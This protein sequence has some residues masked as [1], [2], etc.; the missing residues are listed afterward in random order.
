VW[1]SACNFCDVIVTLNRYL[2]HF[3]IKLCDGLSFFFF[4]IYITKKYN[5]E[6]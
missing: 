3:F 1:I 6:G 2:I 5:R 4:L